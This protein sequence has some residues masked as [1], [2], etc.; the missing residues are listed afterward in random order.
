MGEEAAKPIRLE[1]VPALIGREGDLRCLSLSDVRIEQVD[2]D[3][4]P[5]WRAWVIFWEPWMVRPL[6]WVLGLRP[7]REEASRAVELLLGGMLDG[8]AQART[9]APSTGRDDPITEQRFWDLVMS[10]LRWWSNETDPE[11]KR[12]KQRPARASKREPD[13]AAAALGAAVRAKRTEAGLSQGQL[14]AKVGIAQPQVSQ[15]ERGQVSTEHPDAVALAAAV[16][17]ETASE[18]GVPAAD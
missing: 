9:L 5:Q 14:G 2:L 12:S 18:P 6:T 4:G 17:V 1:E 10:W 7:S 13:P 8:Q 11:G 16:G 15:V 3:D